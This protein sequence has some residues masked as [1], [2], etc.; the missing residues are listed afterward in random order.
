MKWCHRID[1]QYIMKSFSNGSSGQS[2]AKTKC[3]LINVLWCRRGDSILSGA[4]ATTKCAST[5]F[6]PV[7][8]AYTSTHLYRAYYIVIKYRSIGIGVQLT[9]SHHIAVDVLEIGGPWRRTIPATVPKLMLALF[10]THF[11]STNNCLF[12]TNGKSNSIMTQLDSLICAT[13]G[14]MVAEAIDGQSTHLWR[15][16]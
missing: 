8:F 9:Y 1:N 6:A 3:K 15:M 4:R 12:P 16:Q 14:Q 5:L 13:R 11:R 10:L 7:S 2:E